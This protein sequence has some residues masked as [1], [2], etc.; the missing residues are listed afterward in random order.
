[1][2]ADVEDGR[3]RE[4]LFYRL[5]VIE[6]VVPPLRERGEDVKLLARH[7]ADRSAERLGKERLQISAKSLGCLVNHD[8]PGN[9]REL[10]NVVERAVALSTRD[11]IGLEDLPE[12]LRK[13]ARR[14]TASAWSGLTLAQVE[15]LRIREALRETNGNKSRAARLL[16]IAPNTLW[17]KLKRYTIES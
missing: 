16:G 2:K 15:R 14:G 11:T 5:N 13:P 1:L 7:F 10:E 6:I 3:F 9:V 4:D 17:R 8:W 12:S